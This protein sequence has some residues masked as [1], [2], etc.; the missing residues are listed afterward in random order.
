MQ[1]C[2][3]ARFLLRLGAFCTLALAAFAVWLLYID[4]DVDTL[5]YFRQTGRAV[6]ETAPAMFL[7]CL[8][9]AVVVDVV[10]RSRR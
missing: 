10:R 4:G 3:E 9:T 5:L 8:I 2:S 7:V 6:L 1:V